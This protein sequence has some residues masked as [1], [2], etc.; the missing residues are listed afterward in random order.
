[1]CFII[2]VY[3]ILFRLSVGLVGRLLTKVITN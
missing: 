2:N 1:M 3:C